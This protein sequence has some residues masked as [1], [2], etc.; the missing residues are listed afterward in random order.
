MDK[1]HV[2]QMNGDEWKRQSPHVQAAFEQPLPI[3]H[4]T[5]L[6]RNAFEDI[7]AASPKSASSVTVRWSDITQKFASDAV[8]RSTPGYHF[9][10]LR[11]RSP[12]VADYN[13]MM[14]DIADPLIGIFHS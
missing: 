14:L 6:A 7:E 11:I 10:A 1:S 3:D 9:D 8:G 5:L 4:F 13:Q 12:L 2:G